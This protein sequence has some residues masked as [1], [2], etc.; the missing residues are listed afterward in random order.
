SKASGDKGAD[1]GKASRALE[2]RRVVR[3]KKGEDRKLAPLSDEARQR[4][5]APPKPAGRWGR[6]SPEAVNRAA[7]N[8]LGKPAG[9]TLAE[10]G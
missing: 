3:I 7:Q 2:T 5:Q 1:K 6:V 9:G 4:R 8:L 10:P